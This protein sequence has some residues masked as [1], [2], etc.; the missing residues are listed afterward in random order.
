[1]TSQRRSDLSVEELK[2]RNREVLLAPKPYAEVSLAQGCYEVQWRRQDRPAASGN[3]EGTRGRWLVFADERGVADVLSQRLA[4]AGGTCVNVVPGLRL[5]R[6]AK[7]EWRVDPERP[8][9]YGALLED[10]LR[11]GP[12]RGVVHLWSLRSAGSRDLSLETLRHAQ[13][14]GCESVLHLAQAMA[15]VEARM[16]LWLV[17]RG[18]QAVGENVLSVEVAQAPLAGLAKSLLAEM[19]E[20]WG[21]MVDLGSEDAVDDQAAAVASEI[22]ESD[23]EYQVAWRARA[24]YVSR[25]VRRR[26][27]RAARPSIHT[28][29]S[30]LVAGGMGGLGLEIAGWLVQEGARHLVLAG[31]RGPDDRATAAIRKLEEAG[32]KVLVMQADVSQAGDVR[33]IVRGIEGTLPPLRGIVNAAGV[34]DDGILPQQTVGRFRAVMAPKVDGSW[35][36]H[37]QTKDL[38]LDFFVFFSSSAAVLDLAGRGNY[39]A[40]NAFMDALAHYRRARGQAALSVNW[41]SWAAAGMAARLDAA[42]KRQLDERGIGEIE[43]ASGLRILGE[44]IAEGRAQAGVFPMNWA[45]YFRARPEGEAAPYFEDLAPREAIEPAAPVEASGLLDR[46]KQAPVAESRAILADYLQR[47]VAKVL[48]YTDPVHVSRQR[49]LIELGFDSLMA[50][51]LRNQIRSALEMDIPTGK[52]F[53]CATVEQLTDLLQERL[54]ALRAGP[55]EQVDVI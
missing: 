31:R 32:V 30:Y 42:Q 7:G 52:L 10:V 16:K 47:R 44:L 27:P 41:G 19:P 53:D 17:T 22:R 45:K 18:A 39:A 1:M 46:V 36:L 55:G 11:D 15:K 3:G 49:P 51:Q 4:V 6:I 13:Q 34:L 50:V 12:V 35:N 38:L 24:R 23:G 28:D 43:T 54:I 25:L 33:R 29:A 37:E 9:D 14:L 40:A 8:E 48:G 20:L 21:G 5:E 26:G 2:H